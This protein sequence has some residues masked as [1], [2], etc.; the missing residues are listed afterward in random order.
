MSGGRRLLVASVALLALAPAAAAEAACVDGVER[1]SAKRGTVVR[2]AVVLCGGG[3]QRRTFTRAVWR[4]GKDERGTRIVDAA[5]RGRTLALATVTAGRGKRLV[6]QVRLVD[7]RSRKTRFRDRRTGRAFF[8]LIDAPELALG[9]RGELAWT[10]GKTLELR[11]PSGRVERV[12]EA[13][14]PSAIAFE[15]GGTLRWADGEVPLQIGLLD[16]RPPAPGPG[17]C[18]RRSAFTPVRETA[19]VLVTAATY[20]SRGST[21][22]AYRACLKRAEADMVLGSGYVGDTD[23]RV[24][25]VPAVAGT[26]VVVAEQEQDH[27]G[28]CEP[29]EVRVVDL[30][31]GRVIERSDGRYGECQPLPPPEATVVTP[32]GSVAW[33]S[34]V[35][36]PSGPP[37]AAVRGIRADGTMAVLAQ[38]GRI[39]G[40]RAD[41]ETVQWTRDGVAEG[42]T[43]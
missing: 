3:V 20:T 4:G 30:R 12:K 18:P 1:T 2:T 17:G 13:T 40:L 28:E 21:L 14:N 6:T 19:D 26:L 38:G 7:T 39:T 34:T 42:A 15:D 32:S 35:T 5:R 27:Y 22:T 25:G 23:S 43:L 29:L 11:R 31:D 10:L 16:L 33:V 37:Q 8:A 9:P 36:P 24:M 41:G